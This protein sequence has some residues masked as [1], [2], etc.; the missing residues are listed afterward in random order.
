VAAETN[1][2]A[3]TNAPANMVAFS[4]I[5]L[6]EANIFKTPFAF[7]GDPTIGPRS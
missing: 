6:S 1:R 4:R 3:V 7:L 2:S 5:E